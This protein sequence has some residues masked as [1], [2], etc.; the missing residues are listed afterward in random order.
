[1]ETIGGGIVRL[2]GVELLP[3]PEDLSF[4]GQ[5][6]RGGVVEVWLRGRA[7]ERYAIDAGDVL[8]V[9]DGD[10]VVPGTLLA[11]PYVRAIR[12]NL[13]AGGE[14]IARWS[15]ALRGGVD[16]V[17][18]LSNLAFAPGASP[19]RVELRDITDDRCLAVHEVA[20]DRAR[21]AVA[22]GAVVRRGDRLAVV[23]AFNLTRACR[24]FPA[25]RA[26]LDVRPMHGDGT[27]RVAPCDGVVEAIDAEAVIV[28][29]TS[30][31]LHRVRRPRGRHV[32]VRAGEAVSAGDALT[33]GE[34][35]HHALLHVWGE[36]RLRDHLLDELRQL[37]GPTVP[38]VYLALIVRAMLSGQRIDD[39]GDTG[40]ARDA[41]VS[42]AQLDQLQR[43]GGRPA[44][45]TTVLR[46]LG[47]LTA[48]RRDTRARRASRRL[49]R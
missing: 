17:T 29:A 22:D 34:R 36:A 25:L 35:N 24:A 27:A 30:G 46:G 3:C 23:T 8:L 12:A 44:T 41:V 40:L 45:A 11:R 37:L 10:E 2:V 21:P 49:D 14:A 7:D 19:M 43:A 42:R 33:S 15:E 31:A 32:M 16:E 20:R 13:P 38:R 26:L 6:V 48:A 28:R 18:G 9:A 5:C 4:V 47:A 1:M 39:P